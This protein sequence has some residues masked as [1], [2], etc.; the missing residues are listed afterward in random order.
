MTNQDGDNIDVT[1]DEFDGNEVYNFIKW[2]DGFE[3]LNQYRLW[4]EHFYLHSVYGTSRLT[5]SD[6]TYTF[7]KY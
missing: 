2:K 3:N 7:I 4:I 6:C 5:Y 1:E